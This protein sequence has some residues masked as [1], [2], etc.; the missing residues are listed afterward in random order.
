MIYTKV[1]YNAGRLPKKDDTFYIFGKKFRVGNY[2]T[3]RLF[4]YDYDEDNDWPFKYLGIDKNIFFKGIVGEDYVE[5]VESDGSCPYTDSLY[6]LMQVV[7]ALWEYSPFKEGDSVFVAQDIED[8]E[9]PERYG[10][11]VTDEMKSFVGNP[12]KITII[13][14]STGDALNYG[15]GKTYRFCEEDGYC[16]YWTLGM[17]DI[18]KSRAYN[19]HLEMIIKSA[20]DAAKTMQYSLEEEVNKFAFYS[21]RKQGSVELPK[22]TKHLKVTL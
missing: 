8:G 5:E 6:H 20:V 18:P 16:W 15:F 7:N 19:A 3:N 17:L 2:D 14:D 10:Y 22:H 13:E 1:D 11:S 21:T 9:Y 12:H 4:L